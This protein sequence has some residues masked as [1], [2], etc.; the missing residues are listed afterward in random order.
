MDTALPNRGVSSHNRFEIREVR[1]SQKAMFAYTSLH[2]Q[3]KSVLQ[4]MVRGFTGSRN[5]SLRGFPETG[6]CASNGKLS[7]NP[8][9]FIISP[10]I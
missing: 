3:R 5:I 8:R 2:L 1:L 7:S 4:Q 10:R 9:N 6:I